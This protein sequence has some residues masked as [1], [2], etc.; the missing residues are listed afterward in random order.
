MVILRWLITIAYAGFIFYLSIM[1]SDQPPLFPYSDKVF[2]A[3]MYCILAFLMFWSIHN[4]ARKGWRRWGLASVAAAI[5]YGAAI[6]ICQL[7]MPTRSAEFSD[8]ISN[9]IGAVIGVY[10]YVA[11]VKLRKRRTAI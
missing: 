8:A 7:Y 6:E 11:V 1:P 4:T 9:S 2:H 5:L 3:G 10:L